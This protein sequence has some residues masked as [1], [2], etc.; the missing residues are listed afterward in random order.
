MQTERKWQQWLERFYNLRRDKCGSHER[1]HKSVLLL[2]SLDLLD[3]GVLAK[4]QIPLNRG[5]EDTFHRYFEIVRARND[6]P[7]IENPFYHLCD[8]GFW[9][10][11]PPPGEGPLSEPGRVSR[12]PP[13][14]ILCQTTRLSS[15]AGP[16]LGPGAD[17]R[18]KGPPPRLDRLGATALGLSP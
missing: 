4:D 18:P 15:P 14:S 17:Q 9:H 7:A 16:P 12:M 13:I 2:A 6:K 10:L 3:L 5:L 1:P 11:V 8:D